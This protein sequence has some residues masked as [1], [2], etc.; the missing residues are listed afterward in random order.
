MLIQAH[1]E[2]PVEELR[3]WFARGG[4]PRLEEI[5]GKDRTHGQRGLQGRVLPS[6]PPSVDGQLF[7]QDWDEM[8]VTVGTRG[9]VGPT[10][11]ARQG[12]T[13]P[14]DAERR[15]PSVCGAHR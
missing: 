14:A 10:S 5:W 3:R 8:R 1:V 11:L 7:Y 9:A 12:E 6:L 2:P 4:V 15:V 13:A